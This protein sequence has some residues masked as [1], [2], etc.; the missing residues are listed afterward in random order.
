MSLAA[1]D[2][3]RFLG[4]ALA[5]A[6]RA[7]AIHRSFFRTADLAVETKSDSTPVTRSDRL[8][9]EAIR[10]ILRF[11]TPEL[12]LQGE[13]LA[14]EGDPRDRW[15]IDPLDGTKNFV[16]GLPYFA[17]L[18][19]LEIDGELVFGLAHAPALGPGP[20]PDG[21][22]V[23]GDPAAGETWWS[24]RG[25][26]AWAGT[27]T[28][29]LRTSDRRLAVSANTRL[30]E[31]FVAHG[32]LK[33]FQDHGLWEAF[34]NLVAATARTR[35]FGDF[36]GHMLVAEGRCDAMV[37][38]ALALHDVAAVQ[39]IIEEAGGRLIT[40]GRAPLTAGFNESVLSANAALAEE[41]AAV[42][43]F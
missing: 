28:R 40:R 32:G 35:G 29:P 37:E 14:A 21:S 5:A 42:M 3:D 18:L 34:T 4:A 36:W 23:D 17:I 13:E 39:V 33:R 20:S 27:G 16:G 31:A 38:A 2:R 8:A 10:E 24:A 22:F 9:E 11:H 15:V 7:G 30:S 19:G 26:G 1:A 41:I 12:G 43:G 6:R 25:H